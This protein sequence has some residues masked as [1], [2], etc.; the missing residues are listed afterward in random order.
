M[1]HICDFTL[2]MHKN[3][4]DDKIVI[5]FINKTDR[6]EKK[7]HFGLKSYCIKV[8]NVKKTMSITVQLVT[9]PAAPET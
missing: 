2:K 4:N 1:L 8:E 7:K 9:E 3:S 5:V 6:G